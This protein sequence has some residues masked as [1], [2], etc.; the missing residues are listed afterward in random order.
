MINNKSEKLG[1]VK[2]RV[3]RPF[4]KKRFIES[5]PSTVKTITVLDKT[6]ESGATGEPLYNDVITALYEGVGKY[7]KL[8]TMPKVVC[9]RYGLSSKD[10]TPAMV[11]AIYDNAKLDNSKKEF[12]LLESPFQEK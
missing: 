8:K 9:G 6:K 5:L 2:V 1:V 4:D 3:Y 7:G 12:C 11:K 10:F